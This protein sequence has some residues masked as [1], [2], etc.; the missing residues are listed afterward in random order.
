MG[1]LTQNRHPVDELADI[2][3]R[4]KPLKRREEELRQM[5]LDHECEAE[6]EEYAAAVSVTVRENLDQAKL[7]KEMGMKVLRPFMRTSEIR[8]IRLKEK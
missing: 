7:I 2:R 4:M 8:T 6:G 1:K 5:I 3:E